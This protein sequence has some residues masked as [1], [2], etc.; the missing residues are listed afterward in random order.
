MSFK[1]GCNF[2]TENDLTISVAELHTRFIPTWKSTHL[3]LSGNI[4]N[5]ST[6]QG[7]FPACS[8]GQLLGNAYPSRPGFNGISEMVFLHARH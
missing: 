6:G 4:K 7:G 3:H 1:H 5:G 2:Y 8:E